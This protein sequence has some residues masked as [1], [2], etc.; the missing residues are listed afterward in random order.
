MSQHNDIATKLRH[1]AAEL[2]Q[3]SAQLSADERS[4][5]FNFADQLETLAEG[6]PAMPV[7]YRGAM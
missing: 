5:N 1:L 3:K 4:R 6:A 2:R 7:V